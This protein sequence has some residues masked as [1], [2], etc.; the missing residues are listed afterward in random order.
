MK[1]DSTGY[2]RWDF[3][4]KKAFEILQK[5]FQLNEIGL[6][7]AWGTKMEWQDT[8]YRSELQS[9]AVAGKRNWDTS[10]FFY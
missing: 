8:A 2:W 9:G 1:I 6:C 3:A 7:W 5:Y 4:N 10:D